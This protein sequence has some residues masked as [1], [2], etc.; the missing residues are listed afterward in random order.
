ML[1]VQR[2]RQG[3]LPEIHCHT[4]SHTLHLAQKEAVTR[5]QQADSE[6]PQ[7]VD[8]QCDSV[9]N[10]LQG[11]VHIVSMSALSTTPDK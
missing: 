8:L 1:K 11:S 6:I 7:I 3:A 5:S 9:Q 10:D 2:A 4:T